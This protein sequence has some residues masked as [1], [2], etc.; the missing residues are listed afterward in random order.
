MNHYRYEDLIIGMTEVF[1]A[2]V[3]ED[4]LDAFCALSGDSNPLHMDADFARI[5]G[6]PD[7]VAQGMLTASLLS[8]LGG[9]YL[10]GERCLIQSVEV[11]FLRPVLVG[12]TLE[13][14]GT[15][16]ELN[17]SVRQIVLKA[18]M[19]NQRGEKVLRGVMKEGVLD[20]RV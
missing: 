8:R 2:T 19:R 5:H 20:E 13:V 16:D 11:K 3:T 9:V 14:R 17:D 18:E 6:F 1:Y 4:M 10:P 7:R 15:I 12:D